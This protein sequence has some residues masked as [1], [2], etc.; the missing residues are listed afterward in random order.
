MLI[1]TDDRPVTISRTSPIP[2]D[3]AKSHLRFR[4]S[5]EDDL[6]QIYV[7]MAVSFF[8][9]Q[10]GRQCINGTREFAVAGGPC[11]RYI[12]LPVAPLVSVASVKYDDA[13]GEEQTMDDELYRVVPSLFPPSGGADP[14]V[15]AFCPPGRIELVEGAVWPTT[16]TGAR[17]LRILRTCGYG[18]RPDQMPP[19]ISGALL[20]LTGHFFRNREAV[21]SG[22]TSKEIEMGADA[23]I[24]AFKYSALPT[25]PPLTTNRLS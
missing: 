9:E 17:S 1:A 2:L 10:S 18:T 14:V 4:S 11:Q 3:V 21:I 20:M 22:M 15:D 12:E 6:V 8:E 13:A 23:I 25:L 24:K 19:L 5:S 7:A 16:R